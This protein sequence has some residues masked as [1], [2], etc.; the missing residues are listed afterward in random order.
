MVL[1]SHVLKHAC[2][3][4]L[5]SGATNCELKFPNLTCSIF[6]G[7][8]SS[9][10]EYFSFLTQFNNIVGLRTYLGNGTKFTCLKTCLRG[11]ALKVVQHLQVTDENYLVALNLLIGSRRRK[12]G[13]F[14]KLN[15]PYN[16]IE[17][18]FL[19]SGKRLRVLF[20]LFARTHSNV[21][22]LFE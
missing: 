16:L 20:E 14:Y 13:F 10:I 18:H 22:I 1:N 3:T 11:Y 12:A 19:Y 5:R 4:C 9:S 17:I 6:C 2:V 8:G 21:V 15:F 7:E